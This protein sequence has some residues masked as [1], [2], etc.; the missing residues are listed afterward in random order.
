MFTEPETLTRIAG[1]R[2]V[3][4]DTSAL[5]HNLKAVKGV[6]EPATKL[7][8]VVKA[9]AYGFGAVET[10]RVFLKAGADYLGV[11]TLAEGLEL[12]S[13]GITAPVLVMSPLLP[14]ELVAAVNAGLTLTAS[15]YEGARFIAAASAEARRRTRIHLKVE[16]GLRR[17]GFLPADVVP[18]AREI[19]S[20]G[21]LELE[22]IYS[23]LAEASHPSAAGKQFDC[24]KGVLRDL[25]GAGIAVPL[26]HICNSA[27]IL[28]HPENQLDMVRIGTLLYGQFP[29]RAPR[30]NIVLKDPWTFVTRIVFLHHV[31]AGTA[32]GYGGDYK[33]KKAT[34]LAV[35]PVGYADGFALTAVTRPKDLIDLARHIAK[36]V[37]A[38][39]GR[40]S[41]EG[42][43]VSINGHR[44][45]VVGRVGMQLSMVDAGDIP[46]VK[47]GSLVHVQLRRPTAAARLA[48]VYYREGKAYL[49]RNSAGEFMAV[50]LSST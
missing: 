15:S 26:K 5:E 21:N 38:Y 35:I 30:H 31:P 39:V 4:V 47:T 19:L 36:T 17:T 43:S 3:A 48:R 23:H 49:V 50:S 29:F 41:G 37:L 42:T 46:G 6:L 20:H 1:P 13:H 7:L 27:G 2:W 18:A 40:G 33:V 25:E 32:V 22:G 9:D 44:A 45:P 24:F 10:S 34:R 16:T 8:A 11:T 14:E 12:R 28:A